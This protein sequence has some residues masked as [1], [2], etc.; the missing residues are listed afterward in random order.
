MTAF[1]IIIIIPKVK[2]D[3]KQVVSLREAFVNQIHRDGKLK[4]F[5]NIIRVQFVTKE[6]VHEGIVILIY[7]QVAVEYFLIVLLA[8][9]IIEFNQECE[10]GI[11]ILIISGCTFSDIKILQ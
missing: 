8:S 10:V 11:L 1:F 4:E 2:D 3:L 7:L 6:F 9:L 5:L